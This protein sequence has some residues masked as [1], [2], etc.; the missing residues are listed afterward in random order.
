MAEMFLE[1][2]KV[3]GE[4]LDFEH[5]KHIEIKQWSWNTENHVTW[6]VNQGGQST[7]VKIE[8]I[9]LKKT[10]DKA[11]AILHQCCVTGRHIK[12]GKI[13]CRK[14]DGDRKFTY[15][16][17]EMTDIMV[18][19][20]NWEGDGGEQAINETVN[21]SFAKYNISYKLQGDVGTAQGSAEFQFDVQ[22]QSGHGKQGDS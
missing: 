4:S 13:T 14:N 17:I 15:M 22:R 6:D 21:L 20:F 10:C 1:L 8:H 5:G 9:D 2:D 18:S 3:E 7:K 12:S 16:V 11:S 19:R